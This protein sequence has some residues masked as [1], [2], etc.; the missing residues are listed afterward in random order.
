MRKM[1]SQFITTFV[2]EPGLDGQ[3]GTYYGFVEMD[4]YY[5]M[6]VAEGYDGDGGLES[7][8]LAVEAAIEAFVQKPGMSAVR[9]RRC[10]RNAHR[11][12]KEHSVRIRLK[13]GILL[14]VSDYTRFQYGACGN[15]MLYAFRNAG[16]Y[17]QSFTHTVYQTLENQGQA[18]K[19][20]TGP[21]EE[22]RNLYH[23]LGGSGGAM[24]SGKM[25]LEDGDVLLAATEGF[26]S[27]IN[28]V[29]ILDAYESIQSVEEFLGDLQ[30]LYLR[31]ST[32]SIPCCCLAAVDVKKVYKE[33]KAL[34]KR[35]W[36]WCLV[37][38]ILAA[39]AATIL[40]ACIQAR[41]RRQQELRSTLAIYEEMGDQ[42]LAGM[43]CLLARQ[44]YEKAAQ[45]SK[46]LSK[47]EERLEK[48][49]VFS[50][51]ASISAILQN[52]DT[53]YEARDY[54]RARNEYKKALGLV[55]KYTELSPLASDIDQK[56]KL[57]S[58]GMEIDNYMQGA[59]LKEAEGD[60]ESAGSLYGRAEAMLR[61]V[62]DPE[63]LKEVQL[64]LLRVKGQAEQEAKAEEAKARD[65][66]IA[67][68]DKEAA[69][70]AILAGD[71]EAALE[72]YIKIRDS[73]ILMEENEKA[74]EATQIILSLQ[75]QARAAEGLA[76]D[77]IEADKDAAL[78][79]VL[80][81]DTE[82]ALLLYKKVQDAYLEMGDEEGA[83]KV[84]AV[85]ASLEERVDPLPEI[86]AFPGAEEADPDMLPEQE[87]EKA[88]T[89]PGKIK[90][91]PGPGEE[92]VQP[93]AG[94][95]GNMDG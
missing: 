9:I 20:G 19:E 81:G 59:A 69:L 8:K 67:N 66:V 94:P 32:D 52:A 27:R 3:N 18:P 41:R 85:I 82:T 51:K 46:K 34:R 5:C 80:E 23:Y 11:V 44:E 78:S 86:T 56:L 22:T 73:Y 68:A 63:R 93:S 2:S 28:R 49:Q 30:E 25:R 61:I 71:Y 21:K 65:E 43:D 40:Y 10:L 45:E 12:L 55:K 6:A 76:A 14:L 37:F 31:G 72:Q 53:S 64:A 24:V 92:A 58:T 91:V 50:E 38:V 26:W 47:N 15:V 57:V 70:D 17:H 39:V 36:I 48:E 95:G 84:G 62:D 4:Q 1:N 90:M 87:E 77:A 79:A 60:M 88:A 7:A 75:K 16:I 35:I 74:E 89:A 83:E 54:I 33:N 42:Y 13:A 29:E